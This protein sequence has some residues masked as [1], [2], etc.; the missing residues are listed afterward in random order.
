MQSAPSMRRTAATI[1]LLLALCGCSA[2]QFAINHIG[3][4]IA[5]GGSS[6]SADDDPELI[7][8]AAPFSL[9][10]IDS[11]LDESPRHRGLL[12]AAARGYAQ[13]AYAFVQQ[14]AE[15][16]ED[17]NLARALQL[18]DR[19]RILYRR[20]RDYGLRGLELDRPD[21][22]RQLRA[23]PA[24]ALATMQGR[25]VALLYWT[26]APWGGLIALSK[27]EPDILAEL[28][29]VEGMMDRALALDDAFDR[30][31]IH[32]FMISYEMARR[33]GAGDP[34]ER[35]RG[36]FARAMELSHGADA[37]PLLALAESVCI[38]H[39]RRGEFEVLLDQALRID[40]S[41]ATENRL[42]NVM[43]QQR[44]RWLL[45]RTTILFN[46]Q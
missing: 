38:P 29:I 17:G 7:R 26:A 25:D 43:A 31:A 36:H 18:Q 11:L 3:D 15:Q 30:G 4:A 46:D 8:A 41:Q 13:Y 2:R 24:R 27:Q 42:A 37:A 14:E 32:T 21:L 19:A 39:Q 45:A 10:L 40:T 23:D 12:L 34:A 9:K 5:H 33:T 1:A 16:S 35:A 44:A 22:R 6:Y 28:P 20:A